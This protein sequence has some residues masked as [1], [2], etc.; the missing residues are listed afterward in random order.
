[1]NSV[2]HTRTCRSRLQAGQQGAGPVKRLGITVRVLAT[3]SSYM[4]HMGRAE[5]GHACSRKD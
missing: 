4:A 5:W 1:M 2:Q 3:S